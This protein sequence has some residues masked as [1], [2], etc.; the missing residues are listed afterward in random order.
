MTNPEWAD[1]FGKKLEKEPISD[2]YLED[3]G[4]SAP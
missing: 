2:A 3:T 1:T 4:G